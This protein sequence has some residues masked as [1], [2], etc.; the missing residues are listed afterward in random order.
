MSRKS[1]ETLNCPKCGHAND[2]IIWHSL[3]GDLNPEAKQQLFEDSLF[4]FDCRNCGEKIT[5]DYGMLYHDM[6]HRVMI[7]Y[8]DENSVAQAQQTMS[9]GA[10]MMGMEEHGY[11]Y[12]IVTNRNSLREKARI[13][14]H[15]L[16]DRMVEIIKLVYY[17][18]ACDQFP[19]ETITDV[20][21]WVD[22]G[23][24]ILEFICDKPLIAEIADSEYNSIKEDFIERLEGAD[25]KETIIDMQWALNFMKG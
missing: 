11:R 16:D 6:T 25:D 15:N 21:F 18:K 8:V 14:D 1:T 5:V 20:Y 7:Y 4:H 23:K 10:K 2:F 13:F 12:R 9:D 3:N 22:D 17:A 19:D 24:Y